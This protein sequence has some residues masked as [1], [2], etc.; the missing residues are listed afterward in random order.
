[1]ETKELNQIFPN[2]I[3]EYFTSITEPFITNQIRHEFLREDLYQKFADKNPDALNLYHKK[4]IKFL[5]MFR[6]FCEIKGIPY[7]EIR[8]TFDLFIIYPNFKYKVIDLSPE[9]SYKIGKF[10]ILL[11]EE[12]EDLKIIVHTNNE[13]IMVTPNFSN[14]ILLSARER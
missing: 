14:S 10:N 7:E 11:S 12:T 3:Y 9:T 1:M 13:K 2:G 4:R 8:S 5:S 6:N